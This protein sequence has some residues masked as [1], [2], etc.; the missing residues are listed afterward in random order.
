MKECSFKP[1]INKHFFFSFSRETKAK[2]TRRSPRNS[3]SPKRDAEKA[4]TRTTSLEVVFGPGTKGTMVMQRGQKPSD[5]AKA[6]A[7]K[8]NL[9]KSAER[10]LKELLETEIAKGDSCV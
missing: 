9:D 1:K 3:A 10:L 7:L 2:Q 8:Y 5:I 4:A 6:F